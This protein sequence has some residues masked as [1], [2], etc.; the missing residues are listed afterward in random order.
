[1]HDELGLFID[2][3]WRATAP[4]GTLDVLNP[5]SEEPIGSLPHA[6][7]DEINAA[8]SAAERGLR[9]W[10]STSPFERER[11]LREAARLLRERTQV[12]AKAMT[13]EQGKPPRE[14]YRE[15]SRCAETFE[16]YAGAACRIAGRNHPQRSPDLLQWSVPEP[17]RVWLALTAWNFPA[18]LAARK[19]APALA[20]GCSVILKAAEETPASAIALVRVLEEAG[21]PPRGVNLVFGTPSEIS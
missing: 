13:L 6:G 17:V 7:T 16:W 8:L 18:I 21:L 9:A 19:L 12:V 15:V 10:A 1:M 14:S 4:K 5:A 2:G 20:A 3:R 11:V